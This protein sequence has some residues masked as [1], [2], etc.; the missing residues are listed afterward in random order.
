MASLLENYLETTYINRLDALKAEVEAIWKKYVWEDA[1]SKEENNKVVLS[2][3]KLFLT[4][5]T[6]T[7]LHT[8]QWKDQLINPEYQERATVQFILDHVDNEAFSSV[9]SG[10]LAEQKVAL[11]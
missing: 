6:N 2:L 9:I 10:I 1:I 5:N 11:K 8:N 3:W 4:F 7:I